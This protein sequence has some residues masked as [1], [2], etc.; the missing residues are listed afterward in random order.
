MLSPSLVVRS[1]QVPVSAEL[2]A[3]LVGGVL[4]M[5]RSSPFSVGHPHSVGI[6]DLRVLIFARLRQM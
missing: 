5:L 6:L 4:R 1:L 3:G 2:P